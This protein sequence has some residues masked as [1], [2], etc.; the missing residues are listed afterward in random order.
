MDDPNTPS[1]FDLFSLA[2]GYRAPSGDLLA[3]LAG[4]LLLTVLPLIF[5]LL[6][7]R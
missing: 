1:S 2:T 6:G 7:G 4:G 3:L 5:T